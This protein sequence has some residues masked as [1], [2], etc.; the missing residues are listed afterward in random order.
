MLSLLPVS[1]HTTIALRNQMVVV[2]GSYNKIK[3][4]T[5]RRPCDSSAARTLFHAFSALFGK[6]PEKPGPFQYVGTHYNTLLFRK[7]TQGRKKTTEGDWKERPLAKG[8]IKQKG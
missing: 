1:R 7:S 8:N 4:R 5:G 2:F 6:I 3:R